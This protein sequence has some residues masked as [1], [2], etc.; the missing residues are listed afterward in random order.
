MKLSKTAALAVLATHHVAQHKGKTVQARHVASALAVPTDSVLKILQSLARANVIDSHLGRSGGYSVHRA[1]DDITLLEIVEAIDGP[2]VPSIALN[3][4]QP[5][6][7][8]DPIR[9]LEKMWRSVTDQTRELAG[10]CTL[11]SLNRRSALPQKAAEDD[12][13]PTQPA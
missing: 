13:E 12:R 7:L 5:D 1:C 2:I 4:D 9:Q 6:E 8:D 3:G 11:A 10:D